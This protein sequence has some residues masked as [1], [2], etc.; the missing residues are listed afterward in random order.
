[1]DEGRSPGSSAV[2]LAVVGASAG[3]VEALKIFAASLPA[4]LRCPVVIVLHVSATSRSVL[5]H[6]LDRAGILPATAVREGDALRPGHLYVAPPDCHVLVTGTGL[7]LSGGPRENGH[8]PAVDP[9]MRSA[10]QAYHARTVGIVLS[11]TRDDGTAGLAAIQ[12][13]GGRVLVQDPNEALYAGMP[14]NALAHLVVDAVLPVAEI[15]W[16]LA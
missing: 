12:A 9:T 14:Q 3:G 4:D 7:H 11:G 8:R 16:W 1:M 15:A 13:R 6:I 10:A 5:P 2:G